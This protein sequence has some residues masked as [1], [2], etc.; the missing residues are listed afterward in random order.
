MYII[1]LTG[2]IA[3]GKSSVN[4]MIESQG[5]PVIDTDRI[6]DNLYKPETEFYEFLTLA[7]TELSNKYLKEKE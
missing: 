6:V 2:H 4:Q 3:T 7:L 1:G 5:V